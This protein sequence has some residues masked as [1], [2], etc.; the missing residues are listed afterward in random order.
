VLPKGV[1]AKPGQKQERSMPELPDVAG[2]QK[3]LDSTSLHRRI[4]HITVSDDRILK[5]CSAR[6][7]SRRLAGAEL[8]RTLRRGKWL[9]AKI[10]RDGWLV[11]HFGMTGNL[12]F[13]KG[14]E[15]PPKHTRVLF[16]FD[17]GSHLAYV[18][19]RMLGRVDTSDDLERYL[20]DH[21]IGPDALSDE[22]TADRFIEAFS[23][24]RGDAKSALMD[25]SIFSGMGNV[26]SDEILFHVGLHP[27]TKLADLSEKRLRE[28]YKAMRSVLKTASRRRGDVMG[29]RSWLVPHR[30]KG[31]RCPRCETELQTTK[32]TGR[33]AW[34]CPKCQRKK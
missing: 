26:Y 7:L 4:A 12:S 14:G 17:N 30:A 27:K 24:Y 5:G 20:E 18:S 3:C 31:Q 34:L 33:T 2:F 21:E 25:Q 29:M 15:D 9:F 19:R 22:V 23:G 28:L 8:E 1:R 10:A 13:Y 6:A 32:S 11:L 16:E